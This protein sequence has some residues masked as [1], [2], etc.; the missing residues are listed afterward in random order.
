MTKESQQKIYELAN[1]LKKW[2]EEYYL[3]NTPSVDDAT[4]DET[5]RV[6]IELE[7]TN[8]EIFDDKNYIS[9]TINVGSDLS[10][11][12]TFT[13]VKHERPV[14]SLANAFNKEELLK[15]ENDVNKIIK[16]DGSS[17]PKF[18][19]EPKLDGSHIVLTYD[20]GNLVKAVTRGNG[21]IGEDITNNVKFVSGIPQKINF[22]EHL[23]VDGEILIKDSDFADINANLAEDE[24]Y[25][26]SRNLASGSLKQKDVTKIRERKLTAFLYEVFSPTTKFETQVSV[27]TF[28]KNQNFNI[29][30]T[31]TKS[32]DDVETAWK[33][34]EEMNIKKDKIDIPLDGMVLKTNL[35]SFYDEIGM[36]SKFPKYNIAYKFPPTIKQT[37]VEDIEVTVGRSG[38]ITY[39]AVL[40]PVEIDGVMVSKV[41]LHNY[42][43]IVEKDLRIGDTIEL[44]RSGMVIPKVNKVVL[45]KRKPESKKY[46]MVK[47]CP[48][49]ETTIVKME[50]DKVDFF[51]VNDE[52]ESKLINKILHFTSRDAM[53]IEGMSIKTIEKLYKDGFIKNVLD[54][55][56]LGQYKDSIFNNDYQIKDKT[57]N[58]LMLNIENSKTHSL[59]RLLFG[60]G[61][62]SVGKEMAKK[63][64]KHFK[65]LEN[66]T[67]VGITELCEVE[68]VGE[69]SALN[70]QEFFK[71]HLNL[72]N[73]L[74]R[75]GINTE[76]EQNN[77]V[78]DETNPLFQKKFC[79]TGSFETYNREELK[80]K[81]ENEF[82]GIWS[83]GI[84]KNLDILICGENAGSKLEKANILKV[85][86]V[87]ENE[88]NELL[89]FKT[90]IKTNSKKIKI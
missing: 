76:V 5:L 49:C 79:I 8:P 57:W 29:D 68:D 52:C 4:Y 7:E 62:K 42:D 56:V 85:K 46:E 60:L 19:V 43:Y 1:L 12:S 59:E 45:E 71:N 14:L 9:P 37:L 72:I 15:F 40:K 28:L 51:C 27:L 6:L 18:V 63:I 11:Q 89:A 2:N 81:I 53:N 82:G 34:L 21:M 64:A 90:G 69:T 87:D 78:I 38:K 22:K 75:I 44:Y 33:Y 50:D 80:T 39:V 23:I 55:Y 20:D 32:F 73:E 36:T 58:K 86:V 65:S 70:I 30:T 41:T 77:N 84:S 54:L 17:I 16:A 47:T 74:K 13:K 3:Y 31:L 88:L 24:Q 35:R 61:I 26:N 10:E 48:C 67:K 25:A 66:L 83:S